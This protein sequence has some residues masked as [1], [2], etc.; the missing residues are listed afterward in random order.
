MGMKGSKQ[1]YKQAN[2]LNFRG[3]FDIYLDLQK[4]VTDG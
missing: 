2:Q 1:T 4:R 3:H